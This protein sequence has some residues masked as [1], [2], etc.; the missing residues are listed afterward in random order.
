MQRG[1][2]RQAAFFDDEDYRSYLRWLG[3]GAARHGCAVHAY[4]LMTNHIHILATPSSE[5]AILRMIQHVGRH[6]VMYV[7]RKHTR[8]GTLWEGRYKGSLV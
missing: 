8:T 5:T 2:N 6:Y 4:V 3:E 1:N 7:N